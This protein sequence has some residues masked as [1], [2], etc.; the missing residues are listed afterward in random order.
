MVYEQ[1]L[2]TEV[3]YKEAVHIAFGVLSA[4][5]FCYAILKTWFWSRRAGVLT[6][7]AMLILK[8]LAFS[9]GAI[10]NGF[11]F[12]IFGLAFHELIFYKV[13]QN[14]IF[15]NQTRFSKYAAVAWNGFRTW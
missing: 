1:A 11:L 3:K 12:V 5:A 15:R 9:A 2:D 13:R 8:L 6:L 14:R 10:A 4:F 7:D